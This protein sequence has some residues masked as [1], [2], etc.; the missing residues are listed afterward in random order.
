MIVKRS[1]FLRTLN[2]FPK[3]KV[4]ENWKQREW[5]YS[6]CLMMFSLHLSDGIP[7]PICLRSNDF[8]LHRRISFRK[9]RKLLKH[10]KEQE[11][12]G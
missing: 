3:K 11:G 9:I 8:A 7:C 12:K 10:E 5:N 2:N 1:A 4:A 6:F